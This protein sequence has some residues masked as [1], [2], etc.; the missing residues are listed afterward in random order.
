MRHRG[1]Q[2]G[3]NV[4]ALVSCPL[5]HQY[6]QICATI[7]LPCLTGCVASEY[8]PAPDRGQSESVYHANRL[9]QYTMH[10]VGAEA[11]TNSLVMGGGLVGAL[12]AISDIQQ[13]PEWAAARARIDRA[14]HRVG[15]RGA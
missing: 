5:P 4:R 9:C 2:V 10:D 14:S 13:T 15:H 11:A 12:Q 3:W 8:A 1:R 6:R 7:L